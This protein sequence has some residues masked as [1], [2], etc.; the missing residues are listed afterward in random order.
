VPS[1]DSVKSSCQSHLREWRP[2]YFPSRVL[3]EVPQAF[4]NYAATKD[5]ERSLCPVRMQFK[6]GFLTWTYML[7]GSRGNICCVGC[8]KLTRPS[9]LCLNIALAYSIELV[10]NK[11]Y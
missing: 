6:K 11:M 7:L 8:D 1:S 9:L 2:H 5:W 3:L 10:F 4:I